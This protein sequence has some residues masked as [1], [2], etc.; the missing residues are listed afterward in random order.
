MNTI[1]KTVNNV[2]TYNRFTIKGFSSM[3]KSKT[4][5]ML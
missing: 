5:G 2:G 4:S 1:S 3:N